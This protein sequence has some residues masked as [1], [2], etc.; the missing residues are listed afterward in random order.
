MTQQ[1]Y[2][3]ALWLRYVPEEEL[4]AGAD[5]YLMLVM[6][7]AGGSRSNEGADS[8]FTIRLGSQ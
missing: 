3:V 6:S 7:V 4:S 2:V 5:L 8:L 1:D